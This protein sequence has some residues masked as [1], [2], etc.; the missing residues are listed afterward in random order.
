VVN[1]V[2][3]GSCDMR[4]VLG[5]YEG[6]LLGWES[7][8]SVDPTGR[9]LGLAYAFKA[10]DGSIRSVAMDGRRGDALIAGGMDES[11]HIYNLRTRRE[12]GLAAEHKDTVT[13]TT[14]VGDAFALTGAHD[15]AICVWRTNDWVCMDT[16]KG[17]K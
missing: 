8:S 17:H 2:K 3:R 1:R 16:M 13:V 15:G 12:V 9:T 4:V 10:Q 5:T 6:S 11:L 14:F 7:D